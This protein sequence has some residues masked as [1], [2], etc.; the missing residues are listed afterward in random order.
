MK[1][2]SERSASLKNGAQSQTKSLKQSFIG[3]WTQIRQEYGYLFLASLIPAVLFFLIYLARGLYP[4]GEGTV[5][6]LDLNGQYV[7]F[8]EALRDAVLDGGSLLYSWARS[9]GGEFLGIYAYY[10]ASPLS[11]L[12]ALFPTDRMLEALLTEKEI[13]LAVKKGN[14]VTFYAGRWAAKE[15]CAK[16]LGC[17]IGARC[18]FTDIEILNDVSGKPQITLTGA[19]KAALEELGGKRIMLSISHERHYAVA[20]V[21]ISG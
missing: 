18:N 11:Y 14:P 10:I 19:G 20:T 16:A 15:A 2:N 1:K 6:V 5:L 3:K 17:G 9:L 4:F 13:V 21:I 12:V 7:Y 8:F